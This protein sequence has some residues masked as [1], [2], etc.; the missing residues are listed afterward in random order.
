MI[1]TKKLVVAVALCMMSAVSFAEAKIAVLNPQSAVLGSSAAKARF[2]KMEKSADYSATKAKLDGVVADIKNLQ[3]AYQK[4]G[5]TWS[6]EKKAETEKK[7]QNLKQ[8]YEF[9]GK[10]LQAAQQEVVQQVMQEL[11]A[12][13]ETAVKQ[14]VEAEKI[15]LLLDSKAAF[16]ATPEYDITSKVTELLNKAK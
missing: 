1:V 4:D 16:I 6:D 12:K 14:V 9:N 8:D 7:L 10:K 2:E 3:A 15:G 13:Y 5:T 11:G